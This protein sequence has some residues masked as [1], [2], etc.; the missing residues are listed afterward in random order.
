MAAQ[1][2]FTWQDY[3]DQGFTALSDHLGESFQVKPGPAANTV[4][5]WHGEQRIGNLLAVDPEEILLCLGP[6]EC[7]HID[8]DTYDGSCLSLSLD[9]ELFPDESNPTD[10]GEAAEVLRRHA[11]VASADS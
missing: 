9:A 5:I 3:R 8:P 4:E 6:S 7:T 10:L 2:R 11:R 1:R